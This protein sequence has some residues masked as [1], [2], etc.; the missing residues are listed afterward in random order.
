MT[1]SNNKDIKTKIL[2]AGIKTWT[3]RDGNVTATAI[4]KKLGLTHAAI[5]YHFPQ[6][7]IKDAVAEYAVQTKNKKIIPSLI[8]SNHQSVKILSPS[9][10]LEYLTALA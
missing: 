5:L 8:V 2:K 6:K 9:E 1:K 4:A 3:E 10:R 7:T